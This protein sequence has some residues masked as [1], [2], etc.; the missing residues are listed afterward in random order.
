MVYVPDLF[1]DDAAACVKGYGLNADYYSSMA[2]SADKAGE[3][4]LASAYVDEYVKATEAVGAWGSAATFCAASPP[5]EKGVESVKPEYFVGVES[6]RRRRGVGA[7]A[8]ATATVM[9]SVD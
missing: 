4:Q 7:V 5:E 9:A 2:V 1:D 3:S 6:A 8:E